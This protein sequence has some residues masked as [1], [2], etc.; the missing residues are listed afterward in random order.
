[1]SLEEEKKQNRLQR[2]G[3]GGVQGAVS[4]V[5]QQGSGG[6][7]SGGKKS[8]MNPLKGPTDVK[9]CLVDGLSAS[10]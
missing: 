1:M 6:P 9:R 8:K 5:K 2:F 7:G 10:R 4:T 3:E